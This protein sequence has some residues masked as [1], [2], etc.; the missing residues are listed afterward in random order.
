MESPQRKRR[1][2]LSS[3]AENEHD[4][5]LPN[6]LPT[7]GVLA[8]KRDALGEARDLDSAMTD[9]V[10]WKRGIIYQVYPRSFQDCE[11]RRRRRSAGH[12][13]AA[14]LPDLARRRCRSGS[15][16]SIP[17]RW[18]ISATTSPTIAMSIRL[19]GTLAD[20]DDARARCACARPEGHP[21]FRAEPHVGSASLVLGEPVVP[22]Q[23][24]SAIGTSGATVRPTAGRPT[25]GCRNSAGRPG[26]GM[27]PPAS[28]ICT[29]SCASS[30]TSTGATRRCAPRCTMCCASGSTAASTASAST[31]SGC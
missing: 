15:R 9:A 16:R 14:R 24:R 22:R 4:G 23:M 25:T 17:R 31:S 27:R 1:G 3:S 29:A 6:L 8:M 12:P 18:P 5:R 21:R 19:F 13:P 10:W 2:T 11:R 7:L 20:F 28:T 30:R 26:P